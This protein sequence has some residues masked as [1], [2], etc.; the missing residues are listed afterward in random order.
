MGLELGLEFAGPQ[1]RV[2]TGFISPLT[3]GCT[4]S[5]GAVLS[6][7]SWVKREPASSGAARSG[8]ASRSWTVTQLLRAIQAVTPLFLAFVSPSQHLT[9]GTWMSAPLQPCS[10]FSWRHAAWAPQQ[11]CPTP[12]G[13]SPLGCALAIP[14]ESSASWE[15]ASRKQWELWHVC[16]RV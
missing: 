6:R 12:H 8:G 13:H 11:P 9:G 5:R 16:G 4:E 3:A 2:E 7:V 1:A 14:L 10:S 15:H